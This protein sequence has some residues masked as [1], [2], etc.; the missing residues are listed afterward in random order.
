[1][2]NLR[3]YQLR[4]LYYLS[5]QDMTGYSLSK[6]LINESTGR[7]ISNGTLIP[8]L[9]K[10]ISMGLIEFEING[11]KKVYKI[12]ERGREYIENLKS[13]SLEIKSNV[14]KNS[15]SEDA[16]F[17]E[18]LSSRDDFYILKDVVDNHIDIIINIIRII[19]RLKKNRIPE[20]DFIKSINELIDRY[21]K[22]I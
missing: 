21:K 16:P 17:L 19:F 10:L 11:R 8:A 9:N 2:I 5:L 18:V 15:L 22:I 1:M 4:I 20:D 7:N 13:L 14:I 3:G 6:L 12:T